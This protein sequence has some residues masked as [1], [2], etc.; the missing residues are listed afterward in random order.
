LLTCPISSLTQ[1]LP[2]STCARP[3]SGVV[4]GI[5]SFRRLVTAAGPRFTLHSIESRLRSTALRSY[6]V[7]IPPAWGYGINPPIP[8]LQVSSIRELPEDDAELRNRDHFFGHSGLIQAPIQQLVPQGSL[9]V[10]VAC[11]LVDCTKPRELNK[12]LGKDA[13]DLSSDRRTAV[14]G[15]KTTR[16]AE[17]SRR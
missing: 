2:R 1:P 8:S 7:E 13:K 14:Y 12:K 15:E 3:A 11:R 16:I 6:R 17:K 4:P 9:T 5:A 10:V